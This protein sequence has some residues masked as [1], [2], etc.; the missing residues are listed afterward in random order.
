MGPVDRR[1]PDYVAF[2]PPAPSPHLPR[3]S[4]IALRCVVVVYPCQSV[5]REDYRWRRGNAPYDTAVGFVVMTRAAGTT[6]VPVFDPKYM[7]GMSPSFVK[8]TSGMCTK[9]CRVRGDL[10][11]SYCFFPEYVGLIP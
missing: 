6:R 4:C 8:A 10:G 7:K 5:S 3:L 1:G 2:T 9:E 11:G